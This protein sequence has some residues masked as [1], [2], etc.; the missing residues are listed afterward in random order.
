[1]FEKFIQIIFEISIFLFISLIIFN[2]MF[3]FH[4]RNKIVYIKKC[5]FNFS[6]LEKEILKTILNYKENSFPLTTNSPITKK[7]LELE[8]LFKS[9]KI[10]DNPFHSIY[11]LNSEIFYLIKK[12]LELNK[13]YF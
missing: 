10:V 6:I 1:M 13:I 11:Y 7:F 2:F 12:D 8:I 5:L 4:K 3:F 9:K